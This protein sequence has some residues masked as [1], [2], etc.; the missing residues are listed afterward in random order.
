MIVDLVQDQ[1]TDFDAPSC[2]VE[3]FRIDDPNTFGW[4]T[5][6][7]TQKVEAQPVAQAIAFPFRITGDKVQKPADGKQFEQD[8]KKL[9]P[10]DLWTAVDQHQRGA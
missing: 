5:C 1:G 9:F 7:E 3:V 8:V 10:E 2:Q 6:T 4:A